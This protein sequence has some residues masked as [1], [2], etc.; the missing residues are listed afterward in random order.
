M[1][2][3]TKKA[4]KKAKKVKNPVLVSWDGLNAYLMLKSTDAAACAN[5][6]K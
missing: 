1:A 4:A 5:L 2:N 3:L 6:V